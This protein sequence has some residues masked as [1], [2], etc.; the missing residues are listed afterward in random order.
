FLFGRRTFAHNKIGRRLDMFQP[1]LPIVSLQLVSEHERHR[2]LVQLQ[3]ITDG[4]AIDP[5]V[6][7]ETAVGLLLYVEKIIKRAIGAGAIAHSDKGGGHLIKIA[8]PY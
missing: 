6:L 4:T 5:G 7:R 2:D 8:R 3:T 1:V